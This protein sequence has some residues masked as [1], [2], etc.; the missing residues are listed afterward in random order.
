MNRTA[1]PKRPK[2]VDTLR[3]SVTD[4]CNM[5][6]RYCMPAEGI[7]LL[8]HDEILSLEQMARVVRVSIAKGI[9][10]VR[11]TGGEPLVKRNVVWLVRELAQMPG[12]DDLAM[13]TNG[14]LLARHAAELK[15]AGLHRVN[16]SLDT[17]DP[18]GFR[19][20]TRGG[21]LD[22]V[23]K[24]IN[25]AIDA[26]LKPVKINVVLMRG[27]NDDP[28]QFVELAKDLPVHVRYIER[29]NYSGM[30]AEDDYVSASEIIDKLTAISPT[31]PDPGPVGSGPA[32][33]LAMPG[34]K[35]SI[36]FIEERGEHICVNCNRLRLSCDGRLLGCLFQS[37]EQGIDVRPALQHKDDG[38]LAD[39]IERALQSK[40]KHRPRN[41]AREAMS[42]I[43]G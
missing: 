10:R 6:C 41:F 18:E 2:A 36:G 1:R 32:R 39:A 21:N 25:A 29:M 7:P 30:L 43:G 24:G 13:T 3:L 17:L 40:P 38:P 33:Y 31:Q 5:R 34:L 28:A 12:L 11:I 26:G 4:R 14:S 35:G 27:I 23:L 8:K 37:K 15:A 16:V 22:D 19:D 42:Q 9:R 20:L